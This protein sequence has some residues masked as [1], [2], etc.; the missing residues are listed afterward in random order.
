MKILMIGGGAREDSL[1]W[2]M[3]QSPRNPQL[4]CA[5]GNA[6]T[7][8]WATNVPIAVT[9]IDGVIAF[10]KKE[11][12]DLV[13]VAPDDPLAAGMVNRLQAEHIRTFGPTK[14][15]ARIESSKV[16]AKNIMRDKGVPTAHYVTFDR[17]NDAM[18]YIRAQSA[19]SSGHD[20][21]VVKADG[22]A[23]GKGVEVCKDLN[24]VEAVLKRFMINRALGDAGGKILLEQFLDGPELSIHVWS[25]GKTAEMFPTSQ[26][27]KPVF[28]G[29][30]GPNTGGMGTIA[31]VPWV[32]PEL[33]EKVKQQI[34]LPTLAGL[35]EANSQF[36]GLLYPG[37]K[38]TKD[39]AKVLEF[40][41][42]FGDPETQSYMRLLET[43]I[44]DIIDACIDGKLADIEIKWSS[45]FAVCIVAASG[46][47]P[48]AYETGF[49]IKGIER[50]EQIPG[51]VV[52][53]AGTTMKD[54]VL[55]TKGGRVLGVTAKAPTLTEALA[56]AYHAMGCIY[57]QKMH[58][59]K[60]I[61]ARALRIT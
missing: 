21:V 50:A 59:R 54:G 18:T 29:D 3:V 8:R 15:A 25:D 16:F 43:D 14:E 2:K 38:I 52:F 36:C 30:K 20:P 40:N 34:V 28:D 44:L 49:P 61:G 11:G 47:Y 56:T 22:L 45:G 12:I 7:A 51:V 41:A 1:L 23:L 46:G 26:D 58:Y 42:R 60:D 17:Y 24:E 39:G 13:F 37:L 4:F 6:G 53:H 57:F 32:K 33:L 27:H 35:A 31:P 55:V 5:P 48:G 19:H 10:V 9:D